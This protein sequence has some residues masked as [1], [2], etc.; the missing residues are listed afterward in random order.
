MAPPNRVMIFALGSRGDLQPVLGFSLGLKKAG[1][2][3]RVFAIPP[4][5][6]LLVKAGIECI[7]AKENMEEFVEMMF[8]KADPSDRSIGGIIKLAKAASTYLNSDKYIAT[9]TEDMKAAF[10]A[11]QEFKP[12]VIISP[13]IMY[14]PFMC[15]GEALGVPVVTFDLQVNHST[16][17]YPLF[18]LEMGKVPACLNTWLYSIK[19]ISYKRQNKP[20]FDTMRGLLGLPLDTY[21]DGSPFKVWPHPSLTPCLLPLV[22]LRMRSYSQRLTGAGLTKTNFRRPQPS[23]ALYLQKAITGHP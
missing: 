2:Q 16:A 14:G 19:S 13:N 4:A 15:I 8:S 11:A 17:E 7:V 10:A 1:R 22:L 9:Q 18:T 12:D 20:K 5:T 6:D 21:A 3:V 23:G